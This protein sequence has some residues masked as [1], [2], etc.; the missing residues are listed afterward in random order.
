MS[1]DV[2]THTPLHTD[3]PLGQTHLPAEHV[4]PPEQTVPQAPQLPGSLDVLTQDPAH[5]ESP[6]GQR[7]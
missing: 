2:L 4:V 7:Q 1:V 3:S 5:S 6:L